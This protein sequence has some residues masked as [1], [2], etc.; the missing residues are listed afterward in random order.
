ML[1]ATDKLGLELAFSI[2]QTAMTRPDRTAMKS[3]TVD[4]APASMSLMFRCWSVALTIASVQQKASSRFLRTIMDLTAGA[5]AIKR[6]AAASLRWS[7]AIRNHVLKSDRS[8]RG[9]WFAWKSNSCFRMSFGFLRI[10]YSMAAAILNTAKG[11]IASARHCTLL[12]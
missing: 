9:R 4:K 1:D 12:L 3:G 5:K 8:G 10:A 11:S 7:H 6:K 2:T